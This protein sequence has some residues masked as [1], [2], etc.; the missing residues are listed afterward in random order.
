VKAS[1]LQVQRDGIIP[2]WMFYAFMEDPVFMQKVLFDRDLHPAQRLQTRL[3]WFNPLY[4]DNSGYRFGKSSNATYVQLCQCLLIPLWQ[5]GILSHTLRGS[6]YL[7]R[8]HIDKEYETNEFF[9]ALVRKKPT[10]GNEWRIEFTNGSAITAFPADIMNDSLRLESLSLHDC[11]IDE[12]TSFP[13]PDVL[14]DVMFN[15]VTM[16]PPPLA[17]KLGITNTIRCLGAAKYTFQSI[18]KQQKGRGGLVEMVLKRMKEWADSDKETPLEDTFM[19]FNLDEH[20]PADDV[21]WACGGMSTPSIMDEDSGK[22]YVKCDSCGYERVAWEDYFQGVIRTMKNARSLMSEKLYAMRWQGK[23]QHSS[24][25]V[26]SPQA[27]RAMP[28]ADTRIEYRRPKD[29]V[30]H[31][32][33]Y[34]VGVDIGTGATERHSDT[35]PPCGY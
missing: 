7:F 12:A 11:T 2:E 8:D 30:S 35:R 24:E 32:A 20:L 34:A 9:R 10:H 18:Y 6:Q 17:R 21:C 4:V 26:Y 15:R 33:I 3:M 14:W 29:E 28:R 16:P 19:S 13:N 5:S 22:Q 31:K 25:D 27:I 1:R 23:W